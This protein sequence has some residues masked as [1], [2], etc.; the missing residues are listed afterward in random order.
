MTDFLSRL[1]VVD[2]ENRMSSLEALR[3]PWLNASPY[4]DNSALR[5]L[6]YKVL[7]EEEL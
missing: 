7:T 4:V 3:H 5:R 2:T 6:Q 1:M